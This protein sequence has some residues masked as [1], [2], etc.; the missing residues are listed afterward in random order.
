M[1]EVDEQIL[2]KHDKR[3]KVDHDGS[4]DYETSESVFAAH[5]SGLLSFHH[6][7]RILTERFEVESEEAV[8]ALAPHMEEE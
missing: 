7:H 1:N 8:Y 3:M 6:A 5:F 2:V 4:K